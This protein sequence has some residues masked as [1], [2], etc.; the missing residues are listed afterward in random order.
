MKLTVPPLEIDPN[1]GFSPDKDIFERQRFGK[2]LLNIIENI[3][4]ELVIAVNAPWGE[5]KTT[6][7]KKIFLK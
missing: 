1:E 6:F 4:D 2:N 5:G 3:K 7:I